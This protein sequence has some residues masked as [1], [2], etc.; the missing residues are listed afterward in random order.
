M[1]LP[2]EILEKMSKRELIA[3]V[4]A[5]GKQISAQGEQLLIQE[6]RI[7]IL[8]KRIEEL[9]RKNARSAAPFSKNKLKNNPK[10]PGRKTG[11]G[12]FENR[13]APDQAQMVQIEEVELVDEM[14]S[15]GGSDFSP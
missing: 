6:E 11:A 12:N 3:L 1:N 10:Q 9:E 13:Q 4:L 14:C 7:K 2:R 8:E 5:Q 15:C